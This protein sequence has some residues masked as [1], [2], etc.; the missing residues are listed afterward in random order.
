MIHVL[1]TILMLAPQTMPLPRASAETDAPAIWAG[2]S[3]GPHPVGYRQIEKAGAVVHTW[4]PT[5]SAGVRLH[6]QDYLGAGASQLASFLSRTGVSR[7]TI[8]SLFAS[9]LY[10]VAS[11][12]P[13][14]HAFPLILVAHGNGQSVADQ[15]VLC[16]YL[17]SQGYVVAST[18]SP[19][20]RTPLER[21]DQ[22]PVLAESQASELLAA[23]SLVGAELPVD[24]QKV[25][26]VGH[27]FGARAA[28]LLAMKDRRIK[29]LVSLDGGIGTATALAPFRQAPS[30]RPDAPLPPL[31][32]FYEE[33]D[34]FMAPE[35]GL[36]RELR[37]AE[38]ILEPTEGMHHVHFSTYGF[39][40]AVFPNLAAVTH[41]TSATPRSVVA[42]AEKTS[43]FLRRYVQ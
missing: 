18:P 15:M 26:V 16:E 30:F 1:L 34:S 19:M 43:S 39:A 8:D 23:I 24:S 41:A 13:L 35:F 36:L 21:D 42:V 9:P 25:G 10:A 3:P 40:A 17:A 7:S 2:L 22:V 31:L 32:H 4:Y 33:L 29:A 38:L 37:T 11:A 20:L 27:S 12:R 14:D 6:F 5:A 28:L